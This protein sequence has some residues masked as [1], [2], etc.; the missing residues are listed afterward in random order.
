MNTIEDHEKTEFL[1]GLLKLCDQDLLKFFSKCLTKRLEECSNINSLSDKL[2]L[3][4]LSSLSVDDLMSARRVCKRW[5]YIAS[6][7]ELWREKVFELGLVEGILD[8]DDMLLDC[9]KNNSIDW[10]AAYCEMLTV[11]TNA[12]EVKV[13]HQKVPQVKDELRNYCEHRVK[14]FLE[15]IRPRSLDVDEDSSSSDSPPPQDEQ[16][17]ERT[18]SGVV[19]L[20]VTFMATTQSQI[21]AITGKGEDENEAGT[22]QDEGSKEEGWGAL[23]RRARRRQDMSKRADFALD[24]RPDPGQAHDL[25]SAGSSR[26]VQEASVTLPKRIDGIKPIKRVRR[27]QGH[28]DAVCTLMFDRRRI[29]TG[30]MDHSIRV[31]DIR[32][33]RSIKKIYGHLGGIRC[34]QFN[35][36]YIVS[37][38]WDM[39]IRVWDIVKFTQVALLSGHSGVV[40]CLQFN[41]NY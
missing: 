23:G 6:H 29:I 31:W 2:L 19:E 20:P 24:V 17:A 8:L 18:A 26:R 28:M 7:D 32:S 9:M 36:Q 21:D 39:S 22:P 34:L 12:K 25:L 4:V 33:G 41:K 11:I 37:G 38:S 15:R 27:L 30:S 1:V 3:Y 13:P 40:S 35:E 5:N 10:R 14:E 16:K